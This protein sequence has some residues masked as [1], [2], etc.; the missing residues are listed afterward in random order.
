MPKGIRSLA[1]GGPSNPFGGPA[2]T[3]GTGII[4]TKMQAAQ[5]RF[6][7][8]STY[9]GASK[10][11]NPFA[12]LA[13]FALEYLT[14]YAF[15]KLAGDP[16][17]KI[18]AA[19]APE[20][21]GIEDYLDPEA[22]GFTRDQL[23]A[24]LT[25]PDRAEYL[26]DQVFGPKVSKGKSKLKRNIK[27]GVNLL[28]GLQFDDPREQAAFIKSYTALNTGKV[29]DDA[30]QK[31]V[32]EYLKTAAGKNL[33]VQ[34]AYLDDGSGENRSVVE[35]PS[36]GLYVMSKGATGDVDVEG[37]PIPVGNYYE[38]PQWIMGQG[39][40]SE[41]TSLKNPK[42]AATTSFIDERNRLEQ[43]SGALTATLPIFNDLITNKLA[44]A[45]FDTFAAA[46]LRLAGQ[47]KALVNVFNKD[48]RPENRLKENADGTLTWFNPADGTATSKFSNAKDN[49]ELTYTDTLFDPTTGKEINVTRTLNLESTFGNLA[50]N[51]DSRSALIQLAYLAAAA[52]GQTGRTLSDKD[53]ALHLQQLGANMKGTGGLADPEASIR[54]LTGW[55]ARQ[56]AKTDI[57]MQ[58]LE[59]GGRG[60]DYRRLNVESTPWSKYLIA[61]T[62]S[63]TQEH[64]LNPIAVTWAKENNADYQRF[65]RLLY[66]AQQKY[67][68]GVIPRDPLPGVSWEK[69]LRDIADTDNMAISGSSQGTVNSGVEGAIPIP[70]LRSRVK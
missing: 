33:D 25:D 60:S 69:T 7:T 12:G 68:P 16:E 10:E 3:G 44:N 47:I 29:P 46:P 67:S 43:V 22:G 54:G 4:P 2:I 62:D 23:R 61:S 31:W 41:A 36:G 70:V 42:T 28:A 34:T 58:N 1:N 40:T 65:V 52:N 66:S 8:A 48:A 26:A 56:L 53:L 11:T 27:R 18:T 49:N 38:N 51:A 15:D 39:P 32:G 13:P 50:N 59:R 24:E 64:T 57:Q 14:D 45:E 9:K 63:K 55:L 6:P 37:N 19:T 35:S 17:T 20:T 30:R 21:L 5:V